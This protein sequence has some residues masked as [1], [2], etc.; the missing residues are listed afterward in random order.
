MSRIARV[1]LMLSTVALLLVVVVVVVGWRA[2]RGAAPDPLPF[3]GTWTGGAGAKL[4][5]TCK[6][7]PLEEGLVGKT[8]AVRPGDTSDLT[9]DL[10]CRCHL[11]LMISPLDP[12]LATLVG[13]TPCRFVFGPYDITTNVEAMTL[14]LD[15]TGQVL[16]VDIQSGVTSAPPLECESSSITAKLSMT[17]PTPADC[18]PDATSI[19]V[20]PYT[21]T[22]AGVMNCP[23]GAGRE[24]LGIEL[25]DEDDLHCMT[26]G[27]GGNGEGLWSLPQTSKYDV[28]CV[29]RDPVLWP[30]RPYTY[31]PFCRIDGRAFKPLTTDPSATRQFYAVLKMGDD[32]QPCPNG[33]VEMIKRLDTEDDDNVSQALGYIGPNVV[34]KE[35]GNTSAELHFCYF[36]AAATAADTMTAF[37]D[38][39]FPYAIFHDFDGP[40]PPWVTI[41]RWA[42]SH[43]EAGTNGNSLTAVPPDPT[44]E[45]QFDSIIEPGTSSTYFELARVR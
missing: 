18:G 44:A 25:H 6:G 32:G 31:L 17:S 35:P 34:G 23:F 27:S 12:T 11:P 42:L 10:G 45:D 7:I 22:A 36:R 33:A 21:T 3:V 9:Y 13:P 26:S 38:L 14:R 28:A 37:P 5:V 30:T 19:G 4:V 41:K 29:P 15:T 16:D 43:N 40:Q 1:A 20:V 24:G 8:V 39:G 2:A